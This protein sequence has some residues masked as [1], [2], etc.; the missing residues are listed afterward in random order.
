MQELEL[1]LCTDLTKRKGKPSKGSSFNGNR[2]YI[3]KILTK[4]IMK[5]NT[6]KFP[7]MVQVT[8]GSLSYTSYIHLGILYLFQVILR[9]KQVS[10]NNRH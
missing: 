10:N 8:C 1:G 7:V 2:V 3:Y 5:I 4:K 9:E 6:V